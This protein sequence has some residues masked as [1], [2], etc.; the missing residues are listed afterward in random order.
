M[1]TGSNFAAAALVRSF[2][3]QSLRGFAFLGMIG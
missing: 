3:A 2:S 1:N